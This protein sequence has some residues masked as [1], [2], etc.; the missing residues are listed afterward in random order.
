MYELDVTLVPMHTAV[1]SSE[2]LGLQR[3][4]SKQKTNIREFMK[5]CLSGRYSSAR[6]TKSIA[7]AF[8][9]T[10]SD[11]RNYLEFVLAKDPMP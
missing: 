7:F 4:S 6:S 8:A 1:H 10:L 9:K 3:L 2:I 5:P 11:H